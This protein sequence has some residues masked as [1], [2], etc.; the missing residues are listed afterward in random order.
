M[1]AVVPGCLSF[2]LLYWWFPKWGARHTFNGPELE[3][4]HKQSGNQSDLAKSR[5]GSNFLKDSVTL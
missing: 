4:Q 5:K 1:S 2:A 3:N